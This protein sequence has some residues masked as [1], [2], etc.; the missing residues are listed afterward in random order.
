MSD[1]IGR[2]TELENRPSL[3]DELCDYLRQGCSIKTACEACGLSLTSFFSYMR[4]G[5]DADELDPRFAQFAQQIT[6]AKAE[7]KATLVKCIAKAAQT[8]W[9]V[10][11]DLLTKIAPLEYSAGRADSKAPI[12]RADSGVLQELLAREKARLS[13]DSDTI[14][15]LQLALELV[16]REN[17]K[18]FE[19]VAS[20]DCIDET[21]FALPT[22]SS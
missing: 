11:S 4:R 20:L 1:K 21:Y 3:A 10:A 5:G 15:T 9:R 2:R 14:Q 17:N 19:L 6:R 12:M 18:V 7:G 22:N 16:Q 8:D 13:P